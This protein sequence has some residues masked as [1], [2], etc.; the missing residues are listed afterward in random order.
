[1]ERLMGERESDNNL[2]GDKTARQNVTEGFQ[3]KTYSE[4]TGLC[5]INNIFVSK[6]CLTEARGY[7]ELH[8][9]GQEATMSGKHP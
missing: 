6:H 1:M 3:R 5:S 8:Q 7:L 9:T 2:P 4:L